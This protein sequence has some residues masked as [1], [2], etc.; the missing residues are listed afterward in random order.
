MERQVT[1]KAWTSVEV[2]FSP[3][4]IRGHFAVQVGKSKNQ[5]THGVSSQFAGV[6]Q[7]ESKDA[8]EARVPTQ[9][10]EDYLVLALLPPLELDAEFIYG[11]LGRPLFGKPERWNHKLP[12]LWNAEMPTSV[13][14]NF[15]WEIS[16]SQSLTYLEIL[17][18]LSFYILTP[19]Y[20]QWLL[21]KTS[22]LLSLLISPGPYTP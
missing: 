1:V 20:S 11:G 21:A 5:G 18:I 22:V 7:R 19:K 4:P 17:C 15:T 12:L 3:N 13:F 6:H 2:G 14:W 16:F 10:G 9:K 8:G